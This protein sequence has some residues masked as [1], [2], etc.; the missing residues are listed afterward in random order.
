MFVPQ[1][2]NVT[3]SWKKNEKGVLVD[4]RNYIVTN[5]LRGQMW[6]CKS[7][8]VTRE[9]VNQQSITIQ[10]SLFWWI[11]VINLNVS[12]YKEV[13]PGRDDSFEIST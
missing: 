2:I 4:V 9:S 8:R 11:K 5:F 10:C 12:E 13:F 6:F 3:R 1:T 7:S